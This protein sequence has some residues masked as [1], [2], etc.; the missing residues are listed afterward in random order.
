MEQV[1]GKVS[2]NR[3]N[4][5]LQSFSLQSCAHSSMGFFVECRTRNW[6]CYYP[7]ICFFHFSCN[8]NFVRHNASFNLKYFDPKFKF[9]LEIPIIGLKAFGAVAIFRSY[10]FRQNK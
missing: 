3:L 6:S 4:R 2:T 1:V 8:F 10:R 9:S 5:V 7:F